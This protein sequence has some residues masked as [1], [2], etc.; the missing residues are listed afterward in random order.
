MSISEQE[1]IQKSVPWWPLGNWD[2][3]V[4]PTKIVLANIICGRGMRSVEIT[5]DT[6]LFRRGSSRKCC[7]SFNNVWSVTGQTIQMSVDC[8]SRHFAHRRQ[9]NPNGF[10][11][12]STEPPLQS[13][14]LQSPCPVINTYLS[15]E[16]MKY[17][18][19]KKMQ[20]ASY[21]A[22]TLPVVC[23]FQTASCA[24]TSII[25]NGIFQTKPNSYLNPK[26]K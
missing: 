22:I 11:V 16:S 13:V 21:Q 4:S 19:T 25:L 1:R 3:Q 5:H 18:L 6:F 17:I 7:T 2:E 8:K 10:T 24:S 9:T 15:D 14:C 26:I 12:I 23:T 20:A